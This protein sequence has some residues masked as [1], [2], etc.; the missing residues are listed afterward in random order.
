MNT[1]A[2]AETQKLYQLLV[3]NYGKKV[4][5]GTMA[6]VAWNT[7]EADRVHALTGKYPAINGF[8][9]LHLPYSGENWIDYTDISPI[10]EWSKKGGIVTILWHWNVPTHPLAADKV[11][12]RACG[13]QRYRL[14]NDT[15]LDILEEAEP[16]DKIYVRYEKAS[17]N[18][19]AGIWASDNT[20]LKDGEGHSYGNFPIG[21]S[22]PKYGNVKCD[23]TAFS[24]ELDETMIEQL[25]NGF[26][27]VGNGYTVTGVN[28]VK[29][30]TSEYSFN[31]EKTTFK[32]SRILTEGS[33]E[34]KIMKADLDKIAT[35]LLLLQEKKIPV[36]WRPLHEAAGGWFWWGGSTREDF[37]ALWQYMYRDFCRRGINNLIWVWTPEQ[38]TPAWYPGD[39][40]VDIVGRDRYGVSSTT[41]MVDMF[42]ALQRQYPNKIITLSECGTDPLITSQFSLGAEWSWFMPWYGNDESGVPHATDA[43]WQDAANSDKV[44]MLDGLK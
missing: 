11:D 32:M 42:I 40:F 8:D 39:E 25:M 19:H 13:T 29:K 44:L 34:N 31:T 1:K 23:A 15:I 36:L 35:C 5:S 4:L 10:E 33:I 22:R 12:I 26:S 2:T 18:A 9:Y 37:I 16:G 14:S 6:E 21:G 28:Y 3:Q 43:W 41:E 7:K 38:K 27:L 20:T 24:F 17:A 30:E